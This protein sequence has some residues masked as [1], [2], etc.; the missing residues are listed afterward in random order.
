M[1]S[2]YG[3]AARDAR[4]LDVERLSLLRR[5]RCVLRFRSVSVSVHLPAETTARRP[6]RSLTGCRSSRS[7][8]RRIRSPR[9]A[10]S[11]CSAR[12]CCIWCGAGERRVRGPDARAR[13]LS[14]LLSLQPGAPDAA[15]YVRCSLTSRAC[16]R[17]SDAIPGRARRSRVISGRDTSSHRRGSTPLVPV[18]PLIDLPQCLPK[19]RQMGLLVR[20]ERTAVLGCEL[21][22]HVVSQLGEE[23]QGESDV[24]QV[25]RV[26]PLFRPV[27]LFVD[28]KRIDTHRVFFLLLN[29]GHQSDGCRNSG[30]G[31]DSEGPVGWDRGE[32]CRRTGR[33]A[34]PGWETSGGPSPRGPRVG[35][36]PGE[37]DAPC[38]FGH[39]VVGVPFALVAEVLWL[40]RAA[41]LPFLILTWFM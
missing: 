2:G 20:L 6:R 32:V 5:L 9:R 19:V 36:L 40:A 31:G 22:H 16:S 33:P 25:L 41:D 28:L 21:G 17:F 35:Y 18:E 12:D 3:S 24:R 30:T 7:I 14:Q 11:H 4:L 34:A 37:V 8:T 39:H 26:N 29:G 23:V 27:K 10:R 38:R 15:R 13:P 1:H